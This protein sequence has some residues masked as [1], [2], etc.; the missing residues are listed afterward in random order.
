MFW[1]FIVSTLTL[2]TITNG[3]YDNE[4]LMPNQKSGRCVP[5]K[6]C[7]TT[8]VLLNKILTSGSGKPTNSERQELLALQC[9]YIK[10]VPLVCCT[11]SEIQLNVDGLDILKNNTC[12]IY[13]VDK[14]SNGHQAALSGYPWMALLKYKDERNPFKCGATIISDQYILTAAHCVHRLEKLLVAVRLGEHQ[15]STEKDCIKTPRK[16][17][18]APPVEDI[19]IEEIIIHEKYVRN[20]Y[21]DIALIRLNRKI[22]FQRHIKPICLPI[23]DNLRH[24]E[25]SQYV[26]SGW[27]TTENGTTS[28]ILLVAVVPIMDRMEC[29]RILKMHRLRLPITLGQICA[30]GKDLVDTCRGDSGGP[31]GYRDFYNDSPRFIQF[32]IVSVGLEACGVKNVPTSYTNISYYLQWITDHMRYDRND[33]EIAVNNLT[34]AFDRAISDSC[35]PSI[36]RGRKKPPWW[37][38]EIANTRR[39]CRKLFNEA[40][41]LGNWSVYKSSVNKF[42]NL[43]RNAKRKSWRSFC[44]GVEG[45]SET[46]RLRRILSSSAAVPSYIQKSSDSWTTS[47]KETLEVLMDA[48]FPGSVPLSE[49]NTAISYTGPFEVTI[50]INEERLKWALRSFDPY[51]SPGPDGIIPADLQRNEDLIIPW[52]TRIYSACLAWSYIPESWTRCTVAFIPKGG[53]ASHT[54]PKDFRPISLSSFL[55]KTMERLIDLHLRSSINPNR[56]SMSQHAYMKGR[57]VETALHSLVG[58]VEKSLEHKEYALVAFL[59]IEGAF[60]NVTPETILSALGGLD[61]DQSIIC[62]IGRLLTNRVIISS[63][64]TATIFRLAN[65]GTPQGGVLS[66]LLWNLAINMLLMKLDSMMCKTVAYADDVAVAVSGKHLDTLSQCL[67]T[68]LSTLSQWSTAS[69]LGVNP[70]KTELVLFSRRYKIPPFPLPRLN[71]VE[72]KLSDSAKY[73]GI[74]LDSKLSWSLNIHARASKAA[75]A[76]YACR[77]AIGSTWGISPRNAKWLFDMVVKPILMYG[78]LVW[79]KALSKSTYCGIIERI[80][81]ISALMITGALR[82]TPSRALFVMMHWLPADLMAKQLAINSAVRLSTVGAWRSSCTGHAS[83]LGGI[84]YIPANIDYCTPLPFIDRRFSVSLTGGSNSSMDTF[85][86]YTD[87]S[88][89]ADGC[90]SLI[91][92][93]KMFRSLKIIALLIIFALINVN[94]QYGTECQMPNQETGRCVPVKSCRTTYEILQNIQKTGT[95]ISINDREKLLQLQCGR[96]KNRPL[97]CCLESEVQLNVDGFN[98]LQNTTTCGMYSGD[99]VANGHVAALFGFPWM[100]LLKYDDELNVFKCGGSLI[101]DRYVLTAA[102]CISKSNNILIAARLGEYQISTDKDCTNSTR[103]NVCADPVEDVGIEEILIHENYQGNLYYDIALIRLNRTVQ[104][105]RH[106]KPICL[107]IYDNLRTKEYSQY[108]ISGWGAT[109]NRSSS[110][111]LMVAVVF[112]VGRDQCQLELRKHYLRLP[113][114]EGQICAGGLNTVDACR[115]DS[116]GPLG[117]KDFYNDRLRFIQ[118]GVVSIGLDNCGFESPPTTY[119]NISHHLQWITDHMW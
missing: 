62:F 83:I 46:S 118:F 73:L 109:E 87:G 26:I 16:N 111:V 60:N 89:S 97:I 2:L 38:S 72:L 115:G 42:K 65:R 82:S 55:L 108:V 79:W 86:I 19:G 119:S 71:G 58:F 20:L 35:R 68:S 101:S 15:I 45:S 94:G 22:N 50:L 39:E 41:R 105:Q 44:S 10:N 92:M 102:H 56:L 28:D 5:I 64:G 8:Y 80:L 25:Y 81:R 98:I 11:E 37:T 100:A 33:I 77:R 7:K 54:R 17:I 93:Y 9:G 48:H 31:L 88:K 59:D 107:P 43:V 36:C 40:K 34:N 67:Q 117:Y 116:G 51:K 27:G 95:D 53:K 61:I 113:I 85:V 96:L 112:N 29:E 103:K 114:N 76:I 66:P 47:G 69:G 106:I 30:G 78:A 75:V 12:G 91:Q 57:S 74:I 104:F 14:V 32:G 99:R 24:K 49:G 13:S 21:H 52:L 23:Y 4:C 84:S 18:C 110:D 6:S 1:L 3:Q 90:S 63:M 70:G